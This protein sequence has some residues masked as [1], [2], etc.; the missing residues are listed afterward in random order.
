MG[1]QSQP[2]T[3]LDHAC[4]V[5]GGRLLESTLGTGEQHVRCAECG[6]NVDA[7]TSARTPWQSICYCGVTLAGG[8]DA[9]LRCMRS[10]ARTPER[11]HEVVVCHRPPEKARPSSTHAPRPVRVE[12]MS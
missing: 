5:C 6:L 7:E 3:L 4:R 9:G 12:G 1:R 8:V 11:P 10:K 2:F